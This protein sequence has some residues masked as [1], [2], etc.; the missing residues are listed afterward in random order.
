MKIQLKRSNVLEGGKAKEPTAAQM[1]YGE[2]AVN[3]NESDPTI[4][5]K[6]SND[7]I[8][9]ISSPGLPDLGEGTEQPGTLDDRYVLNSGDTMTGAL[10]LHAD[11]V[12]D[13]EAA[14]KQYVDTEIE[15]LIPGTETTPTPPSNPVEG[16]L[17]WNSDDGRLYIYYTDVDSSQWV[18]ATPE[19]ENNIEVGADGGIENT[20][21]GIQIK[22]RP[23]YGIATSS[24][25][26]QIGDDWSNIPALPEV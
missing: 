15:E 22:I 18:P 8:I 10:V 4:F 14:T 23:G 19:T 20:P 25:G 6:D 5:L 2:L 16:Q 13:L 21:D 1:E 17:W 3:Y 26:L 9:R 7:Q 12:N 11:P 24:L